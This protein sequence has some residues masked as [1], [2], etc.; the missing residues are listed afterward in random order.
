MKISNF[1][2]FS[3][4][5][6]V[7][8]FFRSFLSISF[9]FWPTWPRWPDGAILTLLVSEQYFV[10]FLSFIDKNLVEIFANNKQAIA[11]EHQYIRKNPNLRI[12]TND[13]DLTIS[14][15]QAWKMGNIY[16]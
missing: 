12:F 1:L 10:N 5:N 4:S 15:V 9:D 13:N 6:R 8:Y 3:E 2:K 14:K 11:V 16:K 7:K